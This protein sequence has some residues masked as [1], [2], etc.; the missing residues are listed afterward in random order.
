MPSAAWAWD[1]LRENSDYRHDCIDG[2]KHSPKIVKL[3]SGC[4]LLVGNRR[5]EKARKWGLLFF[6][7]PDMSAIEADVFWQPSY[8]P[9]TVHVRLG[10][11]QDDM[12]IDNRNFGRTSDTVML[13]EFCCRRTLF[14]SIKGSRH[15][16]LKSRRYWFQLYCDTAHPIDDKALVEFRIDGGLHS[17]K[18][19]NSMRQIIALHRSHGGKISQIG[20]RKNTERLQNYLIALKIKRRG[21]DYHDIAI[22]LMGENF[23]DEAWDGGHSPLKQ[24]M[25]RIYKSAQEYRDGKYLSLLE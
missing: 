23:V 7:D 12:Q 11:P 20:Y 8:Y 10:R 16:V 2:L 13:Q 18:R 25:C 21:G 19:I 15:I 14:E 22:A 17:N 9:A 5:Y 1:M 4:R 6:V 3:D 24:K